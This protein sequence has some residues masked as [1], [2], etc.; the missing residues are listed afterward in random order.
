MAALLGAEEYG[1]G[2]AA[3]I[4]AGCCMVRQCH[5]NTCPV[6]VATQDPKLRE[7]FK[8]TPEAVVNYL[9]GV[10]EEVREILA[11]MGKRSL[12]EIIGCPELLIPRLPA[13]HP[14][15]QALNLEL[16][17]HQ[18]DPGRK[19]ARVWGLKRNDW[20]D[21]PLNDRIMGDVTEAL[22][23]EGSVSMSYPIHNTDRSVGARVAG[24][25]GRRYIDE[26][27]PP[28]IEIEL[29]FKGSAGQSFGAWMT[30]GMRMI[31]EG[32]SNDYVGKGM[33]GGELVIVPP[34]DAK[35][36]AE[37]NVIA[38]NT[39][40]YGATGGHAFIRGTAGER[41]CVRNSGGAVVVE[42]VG[43][44]GCEYMTGGT[45]IILGPTGRNFGAGMTGG[46]AYVLDETRSFDVRYNPELVDMTP[47]AGTAHL[48]KLANLLK[49]HLEL[50]GSPV[51]AKILHNFGEYRNLFW[52][53]AP[54]PI[55]IPATAAQVI[56][57]K[58]K[59]DQAS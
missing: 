16:L 2:T 3:M 38:G 1:F 12:Q 26:G 9:T 46:E 10:A 29:K 14:R 55:S 47:V 59:Q 36:K 22:E 57:L 31:L 53:V 48:E 32:E 5:L 4:A 15:A 8:G 18:V 52:R 28:G 35:F 37:E 25:I 54:K 50:T 11:A 20:N 13:G 51:A 33:S 6:G 42:G 44:H 56:P 43:D 24:E 7:K 49:R 58:K 45:V 21:K 40:F 30:K 19:K 34:K 27:L 17:L 39:C 41:F 23:G